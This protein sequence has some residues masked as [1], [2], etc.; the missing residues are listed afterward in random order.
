MLN[1]LGWYVSGIGLLLMISSLLY[2]LDII[3]KNTFL[4]LILSGAGIMFLGSMIRSFL[5]S[6]KF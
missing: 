1:K 2:P 3:N 4:K 6:K 5:G